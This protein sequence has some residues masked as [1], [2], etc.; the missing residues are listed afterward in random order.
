MA[1]GYSNWQMVKTPQISALLKK[2]RRENKN[3]SPSEMNFAQNKLANAK[4]EK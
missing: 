4:V 2:V 1:V 3:K